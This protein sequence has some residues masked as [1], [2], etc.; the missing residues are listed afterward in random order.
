MNVRTLAPRGQAA[1]EAKRDPDE[2]ASLTLAAYAPLAPMESTLRLLAAT[3]AALSAGLWCAAAWIGRALCGR[4]LS[5]LAEMAAAAKSADATVPETRLPVAATGDELQE[6][7]N[8]FNGLLSRL[9][10]TLERRE[11][12]AG[13]ASHQLRTPLAGLLSQVDVCLRRERSPEEYRRVLGA[14]RGSAAELRQIVESLLFLA[15]AESEAGR[16]ELATIDLA[17][18]AT[19]HLKRREAHPRF[20][21]LQLAVDS[22]GPLWARVHPPLLSQLVDNLLE[23]AAKYSPPQ[24][25][26]VLEAKRGRGDAV[27]AVVDRGSGL[28]PDEQAQVFT[29]FYRSPQARNR[30]LTGVGLGLAVA[31]R[32][33]AAFGGSIRVE[34][35]LN[36]GSRFEVRLPSAP[37]PE[38]SGVAAG[39]EPPL[40]A[41]QSTAAGAASSSP[42]TTT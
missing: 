9:H 14:V 34:S 22:A 5:P 23:N 29:P 35:V 10:E 13:D 31:Q 21:D 27:L 25:P 20:A 40:S 42:N 15:R 12:F 41:P 18:W 2:F 16:P 19:E 24:T 30:G 32:I 26:I 8:A 39:Q 33:V 28:A 6:L 11:R 1:A 36:E 17:A 3:L 37:P 7:G 4:A 38:V